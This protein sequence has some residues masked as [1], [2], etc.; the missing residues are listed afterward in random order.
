MHDIKTF[1]VRLSNEE[2][3]GIQQ[4]FFD[5]YYNTDQDASL[6]GEEYYYVTAEIMQGKLPIT[7]KYLSKEF[8]EIVVKKYPFLKEY[9]ANY[10]IN[11]DTNPKTYIECLDCGVTYDCDNTV[12]DVYDAIFEE[13]ERSDICLAEML[14]SISVH[15]MSVANVVRVFSKAFKEIEKDKCI[16]HTDE[17]EELELI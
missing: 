16:R 14:E 10:A 13:Y 15:N 1:C 12:D 17:G 11:E 5:M 2:K 4:C 9:Y 6:Y 7:L 8:I 3:I